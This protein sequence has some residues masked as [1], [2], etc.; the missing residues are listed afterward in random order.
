MTSIR[1]PLSVREG[2]SDQPAL[3]EGVPDFVEEE[4]RRWIFK[5]AS[6]SPDQAKHAL[7]RLGLTLPAE[8]RRGYAQELEET[9]AEQARLDVEHEAAVRV[10]K[11]KRDTQDTQR[12]VT[13]PASPV[14]AISPLAPVRRIARSPADPYAPFVSVGTEVSMRP[15][16][17]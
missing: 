13:G 17:L 12:A 16:F 14:I 1:L 2:S 6:R 7:I 5:T 10:W 11:A 9:R 8:Y 15:D 3:R 4:L